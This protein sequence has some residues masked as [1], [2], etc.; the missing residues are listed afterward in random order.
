M[1]P[2]PR[3]VDANQA[4][5]VA[6]CRRAGATVTL[7]HTVGHGCPDLLVGFRGVNYLLE[8]KVPGGRLTPAEREWH[9]TWPGQKAIVF[10]AEQALLV[11][12]AL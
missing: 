8:C 9:A 1:T 10:S 5:I 3:R 6:A 2:A 12:G 7:L 4:D 11:I